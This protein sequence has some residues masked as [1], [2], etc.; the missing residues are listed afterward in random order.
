[1]IG[2]TISHYRVIEKLGGGGMGVVYKAE[3]LKLSRFV[4]LK[5]LPDDVAKD[6]QALARFQREAKAASSLNHPNICTIYEIDE[7]GGRTFIA[8]EL[9]EGQTLRHRIASKLLEIET[10][11]DLGI[12]I[13][14]ALDAA[15]SKGIV[16]RDVKPANIFV[17]SRG[18]AKI[19]DFGLAKISTRKSATGNEPTLPTAEVDPDHLTSPGTAVGTIAYMSPEQ[20]RT[21]ELDARTDLFSFGALFYEMATGTLPFRGESTG[22]ILESILNRS[23]VS[24]VRLNPDLPSKLEE[25]INKCLEKDRNLRYQHASEIRTDLQRLKRDTES[26][27]VTVGAKAGAANGIGL[28]WELIVP[29]AVAVLALSI[30]GYFYF[31]RT[32]K[33]TDKDSVVLAEFANATG[34]SVFDGALRQGLSAQLEQSPFLNLLSDDRLGQTLSLIGKP[35]DTRLTPELAREVCQ[36]TASTAVLDGSIAQVGTQYLLTLKAVNCS[37]G[38]SLAST[39][40]QARDKNSVLDALGRAA[41]EIRSKLGES[42]SSVRKFDTSLEQA[43]TPSLEA[44]KAY[45]LGQAALGEKGDPV[46]AVPLFER[47][48][49]LDPNFAMAYAALGT[50]YMNLGQE[51]LPAQNMKRAYELRDRV[52]DRERFYLEAHYYGTVTG[53]LEKARQSGNLWA[54]MYPR[55]TVPWTNLSVIYT[56]LGQ[57]EE[58]LA[59]ARQALRLDSNGLTYSNL[60]SSL[61]SLNRLEEAGTALKEAQARNVDSPYLHQNQGQLA[62]LQNDAAQLAHEAAWFMGKPG[63]EDAALAFESNASAY[64]GHLGKA[65]DLSRQAVASAE[66]AEEKETAATYEAAA[67]LR[68]ALVGNSGEAKRRVA[69]ALRLSSGR[70]VL[71]GAALALSFAGETDR[72]RLLADELA[73]KFPEDTIAQFNYLPALRAQLALNRNSAAE[74]VAS[75]RTAIPYE[76]GLPTVTVFAPALY[77]VYVRGIAFLTLHQGNEA[78]IEFQKILDHRGVVGSE[79]IGALVHLQLGRASAMSG[80]AAKARTAYKDFLTLWKDA[81][82]D[83]PILRQAKA[84]YAKLE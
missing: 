83:I 45:S 61:L 50:S 63:Y 13:A 26:A 53:D 49:R 16:H 64:E 46:A 39:Q 22:V 40:A 27:R 72:A 76:L 51:I 18:Q 30:S 1:M 36:R 33:L 8:M 59:A 23:P 25:I 34:D 4:A 57:H 35:K 74:S 60:V 62:F 82:P 11:L 54:Q 38:E 21:R 9:L 2:E 71:F 19:L 17:M 37:N 41:S 42:L 70:E 69:Q 84:E 66:R 20:V 7:S 79:P 56:Q 81:D 75:L 52:S 73:K 3:D 67:A 15:H 29:A 44:L 48:V 80:D 31:H 10:V 77:P 28:R 24:P 78:A 65:R 58:S 68:E 5:F 43:T 47:A 55:D 14:D 32:P 12:Q 6:P